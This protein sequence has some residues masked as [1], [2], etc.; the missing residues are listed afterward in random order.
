[1][2]HDWDTI[3]AQEWS[4]R[5]DD[6][7]EPITCNLSCCAWFVPQISWEKQTK[8]HSTVAIDWKYTHDSVQLSER[9]T[10]LLWVGIYSTYAGLLLFFQSLS[11]AIVNNWQSLR[12]HTPQQGDFLV[13]DVDAVSE[14][15]ICYSPLFK[16]LRSL[17]GPVLS[18]V[19]TLLWPV[20][21]KRRKANI[22]FLLSWVDN[23]SFLYSFK[24][25]ALVLSW[26]CFNFYVIIT[27][28]SS[29]LSPH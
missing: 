20:H 27:R 2:R 24:V 9:A 19:G 11:A 21:L 15:H 29:Y 10:S 17:A 28:G 22:I 7:R 13:K 26:N 3:K 25:L 5:T 8:Y 18:I 4:W 14:I 6:G 12:R 16:A 1:M 23:S